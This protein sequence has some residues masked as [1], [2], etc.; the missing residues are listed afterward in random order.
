MPG[1]FELLAASNRETAPEA[2]QIWLSGY[3]ADSMKAPGAVLGKTG[4][5]EENR[6]HCRWVI[7]IFTWSLERPGPRSGLG[8]APSASKNQFCF[9]FYAHMRTR[10]LLYLPMFLSLAYIRKS[11][12]DC[13]LRVYDERC[14]LFC[15][16]K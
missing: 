6:Q 14:P 1:S 11:S 15:R 4:I 5:F 7:N 2:Y 16:R 9:S 10:L 12:A 8:L 3:V 13:C